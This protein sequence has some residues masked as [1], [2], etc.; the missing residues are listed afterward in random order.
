MKISFSAFLIAGVL[1]FV[2]AAQANIVPDSYLQDSFSDQVISILNTE[3]LQMTCDQNKIEKSLHIGGKTTLS[4]LYNGE[5]SRPCTRQDPSGSSFFQ[6]HVSLRLQTDYKKSASEVE[7]TPRHVV[8]FSGQVRYPHDVVIAESQLKAIA[9]AMWAEVR[10]DL[11]PNV[12][13]TTDASGKT[14]VELKAEQSGIG[15]TLTVT[16]QNALVRI[17]YQISP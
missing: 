4:Y 16:A 10:A 3:I 5:A 9:V 13:T 17:E 1:G 8:R 12:Q 14:V 7:V 11:V 15:F 6:R 2:S